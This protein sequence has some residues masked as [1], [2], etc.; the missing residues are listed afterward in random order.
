MSGRTTVSVE[1][2]EEVSS[3]LVLI[4]EGVRAIQTFKSFLIKS[5]IHEFEVCD[6]H[7]I[8]KI[9]FLSLASNTKNLLKS[10]SCLMRIRHINYVFCKLDSE[11]DS[12]DTNISELIRTISEEYSNYQFENCE[13]KF[14][15]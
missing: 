6:Y 9:Y 7:E 4:P 2:L 10:N 12:I 11:I 13:N 14:G 5:G 15:I 3:R 1:Y 8:L